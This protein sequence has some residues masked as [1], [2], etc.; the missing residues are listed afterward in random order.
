M[1]LNAL[2]T[3][4]LPTS[5]KIKLSVYICN[6]ILLGKKSQIG[7]TECHSKE[8]NRKSFQVRCLTHKKSCNAEFYTVL[9][10]DQVP[11]HKGYQKFS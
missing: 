10:D 5:L 7:D 9:S 3:T 4:N 8:E 11:K 6:H 2:I 1:F